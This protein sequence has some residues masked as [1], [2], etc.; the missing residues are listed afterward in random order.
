LCTCNTG[1]LEVHYQKE[2]SK[3]YGRSAWIRD[4]DF[5]EGETDERLAVQENAAYPDSLPLIQRIELNSRGRP[6]GDAD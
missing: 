3:N 4:A 6:R 5:R 1:A 2:V